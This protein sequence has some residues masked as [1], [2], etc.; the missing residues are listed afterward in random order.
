MKIYNTKLNKYG[1]AINSSQYIQDL[2]I[3]SGQKW[4]LHLEMKIWNLIAR[5]INLIQ[6]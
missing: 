2:R 3:A 5:I 1:W 4:E 6:I